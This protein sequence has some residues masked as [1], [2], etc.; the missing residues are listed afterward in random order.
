M[1]SLCHS[2]TVLITSHGSVV[3]L[4]DAA[5]VKSSSVRNDANSESVQIAADMDML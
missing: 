3:Q 1:Q 5:C 4:S 2:Q